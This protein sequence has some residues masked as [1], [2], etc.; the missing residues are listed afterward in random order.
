MTVAATA[1]TIRMIRDPLANMQLLTGD[2]WAPYFVQHI[3]DALISIHLSIYM[4]SS[5]WRSPELGRLDLVTTL[6]NAALRGLNCRCI[7][8][9]PR[10]YGRSVPFNI[11]AALK[12][13]SAGWKIRVMPIAK[14]LHEK[15]L[16]ID[17]NLVIIGSHNISKASA[18]TNFD[19]SLAVNSEVLALQ[20][21]R[22]FWGRWRVSLPLRG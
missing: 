7:I 4:L 15:I 22:Q 10:L 19:T 14:V 18:L 8:D 17:K 16:L 1:Q 13:Q 2:D 3:E 11:T 20:I 12:L 9:Q 21:Y 5:H 6:E